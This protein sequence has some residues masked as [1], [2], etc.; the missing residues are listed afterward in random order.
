[1][2]ANLLELQEMLRKISMP[3]VQQVAS[4]N[5]G[6]A[7]QLLAMDEIK[8]RGEIMAE[9]RGEQAEQQSQEPPMVDQYLAMSQQMMGSPVPQMGSPMASAMTPPMPQP[10]VGPM[11]QQQIPR[12]MPRQMP[13]QMQGIASMAGPR[14]APAPQQ[15]AMAGPGYR[16]GGIV[17]SIQGFSNGGSVLDEEL[18]AELREKG[19]WGSGHRARHYYLKKMASKAE[20]SPLGRSL[21]DYGEKLST[22]PS[23]LYEEGVPAAAKVALEE[24]AGAAL[25]A[26]TYFPRMAPGSIVETFA[27][28]PAGEKV[29]EFFFPKPTDPVAKPSVNEAQVKKE[30]DQARNKSNILNPEV[31]LFDKSISDRLD[32]LG[33]LPEIP[34]VDKKEEEAKTGFGSVPRGV[35]DFLMQAGLSYASGENPGAAGIAGLD[36]ANRQSVQRQELA[37]QKDLDRREEALEEAQT[38]NID[39]QIALR[40]IQGENLNYITPAK[41]RQL[42][43]AEVNKRDDLFDP[44]ER[45]A[46]IQKLTQ[47]YMIRGV[48]P[49][50]SG[51]NQL[52]F[53]ELIAGATR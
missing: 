52:G 8:R 41:A 18:E 43:V 1:M 9:A 49:G 7:P 39:S 19:F 2:S 20:D 51:A 14:P 29:D 42:A 26:L 30:A 23:V 17:D 37:R 40:E 47:L 12:E 10:P 33:D 46:E 34:R 13:Q 38:R 44:V 3:E 45:E 32:F 6:K 22:V 28:V 21:T 25:G 16:H 50:V 11:P 53:D 24:P 27:G 35:Y 4:G 36:F 48:L 5:A 31:G 15:L